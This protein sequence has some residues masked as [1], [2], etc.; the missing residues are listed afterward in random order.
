[1]REDEFR[2]GVTKIAIAPSRHGEA[3]EASASVTLWRS[4]VLSDFRIVDDEEHEPSVIWTLE[5]PD[6]RRVSAPPPAAIPW[7][8]ASE[9]ILK[10]YRRHRA[11]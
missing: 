11:H 2:R 9:T 7:A 10:A 4:V 3:F 5:G 1:M 8:A 6:G